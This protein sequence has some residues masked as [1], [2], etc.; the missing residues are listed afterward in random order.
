MLTSAG[1]ELIDVPPRTTPTLYVVFGLAGTSR[2]PNF[3]IAAPIANA[4]FTRPN[5]P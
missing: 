1:I 3:A 4:G 5:A 2:W